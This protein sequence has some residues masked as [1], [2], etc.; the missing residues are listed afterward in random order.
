M[1]P[2]ILEYALLLHSELMTSLY[3]H[4]SNY[5]LYPTVVRN[6]IKVPAE[7]QGSRDQQQNRSEIATARNDERFLCEI[8]GTKQSTS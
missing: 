7:T 8:C 1:M 2:I 6:G 3:I 5:L 4:S